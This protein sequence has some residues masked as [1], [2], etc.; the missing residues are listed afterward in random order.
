MKKFISLLFI[1]ALVGG[2]VFLSLSEPEIVQDQNVVE[3]PNS[4]FFEAN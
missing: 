3:I 2:V 1:L 4:R